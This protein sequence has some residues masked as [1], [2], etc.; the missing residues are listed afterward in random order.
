LNDTEEYEKQQNLKTQNKANVM[1]AAKINGDVYNEIA[2][3][4]FG[5]YGTESNWRYS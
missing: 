1:K 2:K 5:I 4:T 3:I